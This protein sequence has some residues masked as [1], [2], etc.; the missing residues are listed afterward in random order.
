MILYARMRRLLWAGLAATV[1]LLL[2]LNVL[3]GVRYTRL[4]REVRELE[5]EQIA[6]YEKNK[7]LLA[8][9]GIYSSPRRLETL[10]DESGRRTSDQTT[11][12]VQVL[13]ESEGEGETDGGR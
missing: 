5:R 1:P 9:I 13:P 8:S 3:Q 12:R 4:E 6:W 10:V 11:L 7:T 2:F